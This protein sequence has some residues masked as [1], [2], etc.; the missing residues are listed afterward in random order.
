VN[1]PDLAENYKRKNSKFE[2]YAID[3]LKFGY[4]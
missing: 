1:L 4:L 3:V 2:F